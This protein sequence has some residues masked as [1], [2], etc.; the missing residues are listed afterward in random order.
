MAGV[1]GNLYTLA[2]GKQS[3]KGVAAA[4]G[5]GVYKLK[6]TGGSVGPNRNLLTLQETDATRQ[7]GSTVVVGA[8]IQ[9]SPEWY[10]RPADFGLF[11]YAAL[12]ANEDGGTG[13][14]KTHTAT[15]ANTP[16]YLTCWKNVGGGLIVDKYTDLRIGSMEISGGAGQAVS[17]RADFMG[18]GATFGASDSAAAVVSDAPFT[19][20]EVCVALGGSV[21]ATVEQFTVTINNN[22]D[23]IQA[24]CNLGPYDVVLGRLEVSGSFTYLLESDSDYRKFHTGSA[25]G[26]AFST[27]LFSEALE[28]TMASGSSS[29]SLQMAGIA[30]TAYPVEPDVSGKP[31]RVA[32]TFSSLPQAAI[33]DYIKII[34]T[35]GVTSY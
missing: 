28:I 5:A 22:A 9:G 13:A 21:P 18:L 10:V 4:D 34:T 35:N 6:L 1:A 26:S 11:A 20:P 24:D 7:Q 25:G 19:Y 32:G 8:Q 14:A 29:I 27:T 31:I 2:F 30:F 17:C 15:P 33:A 3:A 12:G 16:P 23:F